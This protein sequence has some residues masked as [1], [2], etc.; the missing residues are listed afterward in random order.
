MIQHEDYN[1]TCW[2]CYLLLKLSLLSLAGVS[3]VISCW[4]Y[5]CL[6]LLKLS[7]LS[8]ARVIL[9]AW[10]ISAISL[11]LPA[12]IWLMGG[13]WAQ[14]GWGG[15]GG[16]NRVNRFSQKFI[17]WSTYPSP[18]VQTNCD[19]TKPNRNRNLK[20]KNS[21]RLIEHRILKMYISVRLTELLKSRFWFC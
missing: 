11:H 21:V 18:R 14:I 19:F 20:R 8:L 4:S 1:S 12:G 15:V 16:P 2:S 3:L 17:K 13:F 7:L 10:G 5:P 6:L 9:T